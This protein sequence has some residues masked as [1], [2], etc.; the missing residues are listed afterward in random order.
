MLK[1]NIYFDLEREAT[2]VKDNIKGWVKE[3]SLT[4]EDLDQIMLRGFSETYLRNS[5]SRL[6]SNIIETDN[7]FHAPGPTIQAYASKRTDGI[8]AER[9]IIRYSNVSWVAEGPHSLEPKQLEFD[10]NSYRTST[11]IRVEKVDG[12]INA[13]LDGVNVTE[14]IVKWESD[15]S[16][17]ASSSILR[18][19]N[20]LNLCKHIGKYDESKPFAEFRKFIWTKI[21][22]TPLNSSK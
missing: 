19:A 21:I 22:V 13:Y 9:W 8:G 5:L 2:W 7:W 6:T 4:R 1:I 14:F 17:V 11:K 20:Y 12:K 10:I 3:K 18:Y 15:V 16:V